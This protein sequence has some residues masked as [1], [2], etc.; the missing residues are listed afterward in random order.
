[1]KPHNTGSALDR[2]GVANG[3][4]VTQPVTSSNGV[5]HASQGVVVPGTTKSST[6]SLDI[7]DAPMPTDLTASQMHVTSSPSQSQRINRKK[8]NKMA[9]KRREERIKDESSD[10]SD[11]DAASHSPTLAHSSSSGDARRRVTNASA[12]WSDNPLFAATATTNG[13]SDVKSRTVTPSSPAQQR[14]K[15]KRAVKSE[16]SLLKSVDISALDDV[17][18]DFEEISSKMAVDAEN[19]NNA[20]KT[21]DVINNTSSANLQRKD[22]PKTSARNVVKST[23]SKARVSNSLTKS[24][25]SVKNGR[26]ATQVQPVKSASK[27][28]SER[29]L[30]QK[31]PSAEG[32]QRV[33][34]SVTI[35]RQTPSIRVTTTPDVTGPSKSAT[36]KSKS[37]PNDIAQMR[38]KLDAQRSKT[39]T[40]YP[41]SSSWN[42]VEQRKASAGDVTA[43]KSVGLESASVTQQRANSTKDVRTNGAEL[44]VFDQPTVTSGPVERR[45]ISTSSNF[46]TPKNLAVAKTTSRSVENVATG[47]QRVK[48]SR[49]QLSIIPDNILSQQYDHFEDACA[50][51]DADE[52]SLDQLINS[53]RE[54]NFASG[55][56]GS[57]QPHDDALVKPSRLV[58]ANKRASVR[59]HTTEIRFKPSTTLTPVTS[60]TPSV[61]S[62]VKLVTRSAQLMTS[63]ADRS[64]STTPTGDASIATAHSNAVSPSPRSNPRTL[65]PFI[66]DVIRRS[67]L[68][69]TAS[70]P[71]L[72]PPPSPFLRHL[73]PS[74][75]SSRKPSLTSSSA[76]SD[77][78]ALLFTPGSVED[79]DK[80]SAV[81][82]DELKA[83]L[84]RDAPVTSRDTMTS[85]TQLAQSVSLD[86][87]FGFFAL[88]ALVFYESK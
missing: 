20:P 3:S 39:V 30:E 68:S 58:A 69:S 81:P 47:A 79:P 21:S 38:K 85:P 6:S 13:G 24:S 45:N 66:D 77:A 26:P 46:L 80:M 54:G 28:R 44:S 49:P 50:D 56:S 15:Q 83:Q 29:F 57:A 65:S 31:Q 60:P 32:D 71:L 55:S 25:E 61:M 14:W 73:P 37:R 59:R 10:V 72:S 41:L 53:L 76:R 9:R 52:P 1:M 23:A 62:S 75:S 11:D 63:S 8:A 78:G 34:L 70:T 48:S 67:P 82:L 27:T 4:R 19:N 7:S 33:G 22:A 18:Q 43:T 5:A 51:A 87:G 35:A 84:R 88:A 74:P 2:K 40:L 42:N 16:Q 86:F 12:Q 36:P 64:S 17:L